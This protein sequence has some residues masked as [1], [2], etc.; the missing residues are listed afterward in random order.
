MSVSYG[1]VC[2]VLVDT[3]VLDVTDH[4]LV[5]RSA[6]DYIQHIMRDGKLV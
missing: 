6:E 1:D 3:I 5:L 4:F 2:Q